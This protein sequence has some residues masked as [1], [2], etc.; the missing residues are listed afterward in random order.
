MVL[1]LVAQHPQI[2]ARDIAS[3]I[4]ITERTVLR[5]IADLESEGYL[6][7]RREGRVNLYEVDHDLPLR[8]SQLQDIAVGQLLDILSA[9]TK[10]EG[11]SA[12]SGN[13]K[14]SDDTPPGQ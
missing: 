13:S 7:K 10:V 8:H 2:T 12:R 4:G 5:I 6:Q 11:H 1:G 9:I 3:H 14:G